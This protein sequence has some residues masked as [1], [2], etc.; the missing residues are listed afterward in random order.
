MES[1]AASDVVAERSV[2]LAVCHMVDWLRWPMPANISQCI[3][4]FIRHLAI[5]QKYS[6]LMEIAELKVMQVSCLSV[7]M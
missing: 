4:L 3:V 7:H 1:L 6:V 2:L 5:A